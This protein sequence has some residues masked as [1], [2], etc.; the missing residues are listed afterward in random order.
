MILLSS[1]IFPQCFPSLTTNILSLIKLYLCTGAGQ[2]R[3]CEGRKPSW[4][5]HLF[6]SAGWCECSS[7]KCGGYT[8]RLQ[9]VWLL[10]TRSK[11]SRSF[12]L[13]VREDSTLYWLGSLQGT[14][15][16]SD[17]HIVSLCD[18]ARSLIYFSLADSFSQ[19]SQIIVFVLVVWNF[20]SEWRLICELVVMTAKTADTLSKWEGSGGRW[21][22]ESNLLNA[23]ATGGPWIR[24]VVTH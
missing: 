24:A 9:C 2:F 1:N 12:S 17:H 5:L 11:S 4:G 18:N 15:L 16:S 20:C 7:S 22:D 3:K 10:C 8:A 13:A 19:K 14:F 23:I 6:T 21:E